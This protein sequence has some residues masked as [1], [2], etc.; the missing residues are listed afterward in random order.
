MRPALPA[1]LHTWLAVLSAPP[2]RSSTRV[3]P[4][5]ACA[6]KAAE[7][8][9]SASMPQAFAVVVFQWPRDWRPM[10][11]VRSRGRSSRQAGS[12]IASN[13]MRTALASAPA[14]IHHH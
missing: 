1:L 11:P 5:G 13:T 3:T 7:N 9:R 6:S 8:L 10:V 12:S 4:P 2:W 14:M